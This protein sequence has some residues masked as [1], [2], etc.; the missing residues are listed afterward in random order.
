MAGEKEGGPVI[1][2]NAAGAGPGGEGSAAAGT[3]GGAV[4]DQEITLNVGG[5]EV[6]LKTSDILDDRGVPFK[7]M[8][9]ELQRK[10]DEANST[11]QQIQEQ[12][13]KREE[14]KVEE[15]VGQFIDPTD[16][17]TYTEE[18]LNR[19]MMVGEGTK[20]LRIVMNPKQ[21]GRVVDQAI[22]AREA[23]AETQRRYPDLKNPKSEFFVRTAMYMQSRGLFDHP[24]GLALASAAVAEDMRSEGKEFTTGTFGSPEAQRRSQ[25]SGT[26]VRGREGSGLPSGSE[27]EL[28]DA[29][30]A[31]ATKLGVD[32]KKM[33][34]RLENYLASKGQR[35]ED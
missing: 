5:K 27:S 2:P 25:N 10:L 32:P 19:M 6:K 14:E 29:G 9:G 12:G 21:V 30:K 24:A 18:D 11:L 33:A 31:M 34:K 13:G 22:S 28:D 1:D 4:Q 3:G 7:Q 16:G 26:V 8:T 35:R 23:K 20:A 15:K 17:K